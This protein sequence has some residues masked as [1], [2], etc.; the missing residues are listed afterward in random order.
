MTYLATNPYSME[1]LQKRFPVILTESYLTSA[2][3]VKETFLPGKVMY[4]IG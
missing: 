1:S 3:S 4:A 2:C